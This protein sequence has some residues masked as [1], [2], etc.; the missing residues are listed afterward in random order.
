MPYMCI[1]HEVQLGETSTCVQ[2]P[3]KCHVTNVEKLAKMF[4]L[5]GWMQIAVT[6][7]I[8]IINVA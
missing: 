3:S 6:H 1:K 4:V 5:S 8:F 2:S 7:Q